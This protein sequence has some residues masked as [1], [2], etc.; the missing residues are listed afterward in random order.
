MTTKELEALSIATQKQIAGTMPQAG[1]L[2]KMGIGEGAFKL[3]IKQGDVMSWLDTGQFR[4]QPVNGQIDW[5]NRTIGSWVS[6]GTSALLGQLGKTMEDFRTL[7]SSDYRSQYFTRTQT[8]NRTTYAPIAGFSEKTIGTEAFTGMFGQPAT[9]STVQPSGISPVVPDAITPESSISGIQSVFGAN[10]QPSPAFTPELQA[11]GIFGA[12][13]ITGTN[14]VYTIG[15]GGRKETA[16]SFLQRFGTAEQEGIVGEISREQA[17]KLGVTDTG[18][19]PVAPGAITP[20]DMETTE[21]IDV[22]GGGGTT[23][24]GG[25]ALATTTTASVQSY[26]DIL[27]AGKSAQQLE[28]E[29]EI[30]TLEESIKTSLTELEGQGAAQLAAEDEQGV[31]AKQQALDDANANMTM[32]LAEIAALE[33]DYNL[34]TQAIEG[35]AITMGSIQGQKAQEY[36]MF[37][38]QKNVLVSEA[39]LLQAQALGLQGRLDTAQD[40]ANR[41]VDLK[42]ADIETRLALQ[43]Q[44][45]GVLEGQVSA[46]EQIRLSAIELYIQDQQNTLN[47]QKAQERAVYQT[48]LSQIQKYPDAQINITDTLEQANAKITTNSAIY[49]QA[50]RLAGGATGAGG[51]GIAPTGE[52]SDW[53]YARQIIAD[54][55][56]ASEE[57]LKAGLFENTDLNVSEIN[58]LITTRPQAETYS[59]DWFQARVDDSKAQGYSADEITNFLIGEFS[60]D[61]LFKKAK[62]MGFAEWYTGKK[63]DIKRYIESLM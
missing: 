63:T 24:D 55:P 45:L 42:Y 38:A 53:D 52:V 40:A 9:P 61:E 27:N 26:I 57:E 37:L 29:E 58:S 6:G 23:G 17:L 50:T 41:A 16:E 39:A 14:E 59:D 11:Q 12:V 18:Q 7:N 60:E 47:D 19:T 25:A 20:E 5:Q 1:E 31:L 15:P 10:W 46:D 21:P 22:P 56:N 44:L 2:V 30:D 8:P 35:K 13:R 36:K 43:T 48:L 62:E 28:A 33:A 54:N 32:K 34:K 3:G 49:R 4:P 51:A